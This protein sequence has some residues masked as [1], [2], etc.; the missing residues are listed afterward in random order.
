MAHSRD[1]S[2][3]TQFSPLTPPR[4][5]T[6]LSASWLMTRHSAS[7]SSPVSRIVLAAKTAM[8]KPLQAS[9]SAPS[10]PKPA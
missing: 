7:S 6:L 5:S 10:L 1:A 3:F 4:Y 2:D 8:G 9:A